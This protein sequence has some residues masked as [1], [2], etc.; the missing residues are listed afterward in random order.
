MRL[1]G[2][3]SLLVAGAVLDTFGIGLILPFVYYLDNTERILDTKL[4]GSALRTAQITSPAAISVAMAA[5]LVFY[6]IVKNLYIALQ[7]NLIFSFLMRKQ[8]AVSDELVARY[9]HAPYAFHLLHNSSELTRNVQEVINMFGGVLL[10]GIL[11]LREILILILI[12]ALVMAIQ[13]VNNNGT[14]VM[15]PGF[16]LV[17]MT[18]IVVGR[19]LQKRAATMGRIRVE[20]YEDMIRDVRMIRGGIKELKVLGREDH[21]IGSFSQS[22]ATVSRVLQKTQVYGEYPRLVLE[23]MAMLV[24]AMAVVG[25]FLSGGDLQSSLPTLALLGAA[26]LRLIPAANRISSSYNSIRFGIGGAEVVLTQLDELRGA[27]RP[28]AH[29]SKEG[30][31]YD[32]RI[33]VQ[34][35]CY[36]YEGANVDA[37]SDVSLEIP[38]GSFVAF[39]GA[40]GSGKTTLANVLLGLLP[41]TTGSVQVDGQPLGRPSERG[42]GLMGYVPQDVYLADLSLRENVAFGVPNDRINDERVFR[43]LARAQLSEFVSELPNGIHTRLGEDGARLSGGQRQRVGIARALYDNPPILVLDEATSALDHATDHEIMTEVAGLKRHHTIMVITHRVVGTEPC[44][45]IYV[46]DKGSICATGTYS[47]LSASSVC[48]RKLLPFG[49]QDSAS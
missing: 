35:L 41:P 38:K 10:P 2:L 47:E 37:L 19:V 23:T 27:S 34:G 33:L 20:A 7:W 42:T 13:I 44:D 16:I 8:V 26:I 25:I 17:G 6:F 40:S 39:V 3:F 49:S 21:F 43:A 15:L 31:S 22:S 5:T 28:K 11:L 4:I 45:A 1:H 29:M 36:R 18:V 14:I 9:A 32:D 24:I 30:L 46:L 48:F 12:I